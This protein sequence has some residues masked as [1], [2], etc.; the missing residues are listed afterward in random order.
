[1]KTI[2]EHSI[3][4]GFLI[5][6]KT[7]T[8]KLQYYDLKLYNVHGEHD[9]FLD[10]MLEI[11]KESSNLLSVERDIDMI[12]F[13]KIKNVIHGE[14]KIILEYK[15]AKTETY[16][17][18]LDDSPKSTDFLKTLEESLSVANQNKDQ[19]RNKNIKEFINRH[20]FLQEVNN[21]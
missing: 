18:E 16:S 8:F 13:D 17:I 7:T 11:T 4:K 14:K 10:F 9:I 19:S 6:K 3:K 2:I 20:R 15:L 1:M 21:G 5:N 12:P